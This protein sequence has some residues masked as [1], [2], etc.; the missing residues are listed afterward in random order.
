MNQSAT[1]MKKPANGGLFKVTN[2]A[3]SRAYGWPPREATTLASCDFLR[4]ALFG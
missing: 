2:V 3:L 1:Q 4:A